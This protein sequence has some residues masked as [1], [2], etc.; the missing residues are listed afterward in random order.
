[1]TR[2]R[3]ASVLALLC[4]AAA[5]TAAP[6]ADP[7]LTKVNGAIEIGAGQHSGDLSTVNG[8]V[9]IG[10]N[11]VV[12]HTSTVNGSIT[13]EPHASAGALS[14][15]NGA[16]HVQQAAHVN[17]GVQ[18]VNGKLS[19]DDEAD[20]GGGLGNVNG[21][22]SVAAAHVGG[23][24]DTASGDIQLG[25]NARVDGGIHVQEDTSWF[26]LWFWSEDIPRIV[27]GPGTV[28]GGTLKF[29]RKVHLY[30]S[31]RATIG[32]VQGASAIKFSGDAPP[33]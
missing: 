23:M 24:I 18:A 30:V 19:V 2:S 7:S 9:K 26:H 12:G 13:L 33:K 32:P 6:G 10:S 16:V 15:V 17:G 31:D 8:S 20:V 28:V 27:I 3:A 29:E 4:G 21:A 5:A 1:M 25:P 22:I 14:T 11:A